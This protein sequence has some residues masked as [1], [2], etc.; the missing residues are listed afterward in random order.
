MEILVTGGA[1]FIG[2]H[3]VEALVAGGHGVAVLDDFND[4]YSPLLKHANLAG[5][6][7][8]V[9]I[10]AVDVREADAVARVVERGR[11][12]TIIHLAARAGVRPSIE[13]PRLYV[14]TNISGTLN[15]L[16]AARLGEVKRFIFASSS[17]VYGLCPTVPFR[18]DL[19]L[20]E[21]ISPYAA[22][23][24][25]G[26]Q[27]CA[28]YAH[29]HGIRTVCL[30][31]F[32]AYGPRLR[33]DLAIHLFTSRILRG[34][35][36]EQF[37]DGSM[38]RDYTYIDDTI[39]GVLGALAYDGPIFDLFNLGESD[40]T[41]LSTLIRLIEAALGKEARIKLMPERPGDVPLT[42]ADISK[43]RRLLGYQ[44][45]TPI[46]QGIPRFVNW[47]LANQRTASPANGAGPDPSARRPASGKAVAAAAL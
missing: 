6:E 33:P 45:S 34:E 32:N 29:L 21:T 35:P 30:R 23:K 15:L 2:S 3:L 31:F 18:E 25:A 27:L 38:R 10:H 22:T 11:F 36:I 40:T 26:E 41:T 39:Q 13:Q 8:R 12:D 19:P 44:P 43:A 47:Y 9:E 37:G 5:V 16:E 14:D 7:D 42:Y 17:S 28:N 24:L 1:G 4:F 46:S 20:C